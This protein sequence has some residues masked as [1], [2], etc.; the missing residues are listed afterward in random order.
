M[1]VVLSTWAFKLKRCPDGRVKKFKARFC[2]QGD[3]QKECFYYFE[4]WAPVVQ[5]LTVQIVII[6]A[7][8]M[9]L[10]SIQC[11]IT[12]AFIH[13]RVTETI[14][15]YQPQGFNCGKGDE[16]LCLKRTLYLYGLKQLPQYFFHYLTECLIKQ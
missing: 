13:G 7:I 15:V 11:N 8:K 3:R 6:L 14:Y 1:N 5:W 9:K 2:A 4:T 16:V 10:S 12:V